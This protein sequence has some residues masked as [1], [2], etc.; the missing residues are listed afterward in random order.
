MSYVTDVLLIGSYGIHEEVEEF[1]AWCLEH[2]PERK[3]QLRPLDMDG[4]G[5]TKVIGAR[6][7]AMGGNYF[8]WY[9]LRNAVLA[10]LLRLLPGHMLRIEPEDGARVVLVSTWD[11]GIV[12][13]RDD[14]A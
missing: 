4:A 6:V 10:G 14:A 11:R 2:D 9:D 8:P 5:G 13:V 12:E 3:Q 7:Y 1:N